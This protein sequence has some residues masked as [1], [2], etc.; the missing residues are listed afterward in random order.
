MFFDVT[1]DGY[2]QTFDLCSHPGAPFRAGGNRKACGLLMAFKFY[3]KERNLSIL[4]SPRT[5]QRAAMFQSTS[6]WF[7]DRLCVYRP[8][9]N[10]NI[11]AFRVFL[12]KQDASFFLRD[13]P[14][15]QRIHSSIQ[16]VCSL[17]PVPQPCRRRLSE[18]GSV[19]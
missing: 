19:L 2:F 10:L 1:S 13:V 4:K 5:C 6:P 15:F 7:F 18:K 3:F 8:F 14:G 11:P 9:G 17:C 12:G 16:F